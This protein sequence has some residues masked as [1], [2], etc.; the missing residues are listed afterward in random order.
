MD[1]IIKA[2]KRKVIFGRISVWKLDPCREHNSPCFI[3]Y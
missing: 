1:S 3:I 2:D